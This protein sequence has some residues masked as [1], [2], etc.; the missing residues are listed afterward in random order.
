MQVGGNSKSAEEDKAQHV[1]SIAWVSSDTAK[2][3]HSRAKIPVITLLLSPP[4]PQ[5]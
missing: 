3:R 1:S 4:G 2:Q 5:F